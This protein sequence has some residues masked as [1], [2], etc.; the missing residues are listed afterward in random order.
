MISCELNVFVRARIL[1]SLITVE[2]Y[3]YHLNIGDYFSAEIRLQGSQQ[4]V[5]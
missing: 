2:F 4:H 5:D 3:F 1:F